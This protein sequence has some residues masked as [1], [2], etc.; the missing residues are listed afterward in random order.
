[1]H[2]RSRRDADASMASFEKDAG[3]GE[4][5]VEDRRLDPVDEALRNK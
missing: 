2:W 3:N 1:M 5:H 4:L